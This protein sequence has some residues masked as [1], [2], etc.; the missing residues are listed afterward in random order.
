MLSANNLN[1][2]LC[3]RFAGTRPARSVG[4]FPCSSD[5]PAPGSPFTFT[6]QRYNGHRKAVTWH[7]LWYLSG[8]LRPVFKAARNIRAGN[9]KLVFPATLMING[10]TVKNFFPDSITICM[11]PLTI[12]KGMHSHKFIQEPVVKGNIEQRPEQLTFGF[13]HEV[14]E[15]C[16]EPGQSKQ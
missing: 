1:I 3:S 6:D 12:R 14:R 16:T 8:L 15:S 13:S 9:V 4:L 5:R 2:K 11:L 7:Y 10:G